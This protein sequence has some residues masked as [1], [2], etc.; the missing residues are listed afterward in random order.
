M[1][2]CPPLVSMK[3]LCE[4]FPDKNPVTVYRWRNTTGRMRLPEPDLDVDGH[5]VLWSVQTITA[6]A[7]ERKLALDESVL[8]RICKDQDS[9]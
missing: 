4:L 2:V 7:A 5:A 9:V 1:T 8:E 6:W 3:L